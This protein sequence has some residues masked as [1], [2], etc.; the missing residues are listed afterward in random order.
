LGWQLLKL[1]AEV[2]PEWPKL[3]WAKQKLFAATAWLPQQQ[4]QQPL[5]VVELGWPEPERH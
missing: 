2:A 4:Q 1:V 3:F 5:L